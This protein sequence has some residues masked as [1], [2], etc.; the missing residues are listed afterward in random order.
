MQNFKKL[1]RAEMKNV[2]GG[3]GDPPHCTIGSPCNGV[4]NHIITAGTCNSACTC[5]V[6]NDGQRNDCALN[7]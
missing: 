5:S 6:G 7:S 2:K 4:V 3:V 1:S